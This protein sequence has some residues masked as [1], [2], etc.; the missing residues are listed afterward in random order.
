MTLEPIPIA[1][2]WLHRWWTATLR[3]WRASPALFLV[4]YLM[5]AAYNT[6]WF[7]YVWQ[8]LAESIGIPLKKPAR[9]RV[10]QSVGQQRMDT[11]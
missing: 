7:I 2:G 5:L 4:V 11:A 10:P 3:S 6:I 8:F 9:G 1:P